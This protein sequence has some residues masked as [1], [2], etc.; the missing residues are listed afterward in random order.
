MDSIHLNCSNFENFFIPRISL[1][2]SFSFKICE[3][4]SSIIKHTLAGKSLKNTF[5]SSMEESAFPVNELN[6][7]IT[8]SSKFTKRFI[9]EISTIQGNIDISFSSIAETTDT[10]YSFMKKDFPAPAVPVTINT[11]LKCGLRKKLL[12]LLT[13]LY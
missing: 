4:R 12:S 13:R 3:F 11:L 2:Q 1:S 6:S 5:A 10:I 8:K 7:A 9:F